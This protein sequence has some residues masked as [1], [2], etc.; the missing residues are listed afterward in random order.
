MCTA[1]ITAMDFR[2]GMNNI[3]IKKGRE[4]EENKRGWKTVATTIVMVVVGQF[5]LNRVS[6]KAKPSITNPV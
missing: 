3:S 6:A 4:E 5:V 1:F 2:K